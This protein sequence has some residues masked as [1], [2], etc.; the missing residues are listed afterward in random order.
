ML[1]SV[2]WPVS[3]LQW[4]RALPQPGHPS[5]MSSSGMMP[6]DILIRCCDHVQTRKLSMHSGIDRNEM[7]LPPSQM[8]LFNRI[9]LNLQMYLFKLKMCICPNFK[10]F[11]WAEYSHDKDEESLSARPCDS[12][13]LAFYVQPGSRTWQTHYWWSWC[14]WTWC[15]WS[16]WRGRWRGCPWPK[17]RPCRLAGQNQMGQ[18]APS[19]QGA[20]SPQTAQETAEACKLQKGK[21]LITKKTPRH[22]SDITLLDRKLFPAQRLKELTLFLKVNHTPELVRLLPI[23]R[24]LKTR[25]G[26]ISVKIIIVTFINFVRLAIAC[27]FFGTTN[28]S[29]ACSA[30]TLQLGTLKTWIT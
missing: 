15:A 24:V 18:T 17:T 23:L 10:S 14:W 29:K 25:K 2:T 8:A 3:R 16:G 1:M 19:S 7:M 4:S 28:P 26:E 9:W 21:K 5:E 22:I 30:V 6:F 13:G 11:L 27:E 12:Q 20:T